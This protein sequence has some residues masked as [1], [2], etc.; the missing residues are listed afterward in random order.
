MADNANIYPN[1]SEICDVGLNFLNIE[2]SV[3]WVPPLDIGLIGDGQLRTEIR[4]CKCF[5]E[6]NS[7]SDGVKLSDLGLLY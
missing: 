6:L 3:S 7:I 5:I 2:I 4:Y 1:G